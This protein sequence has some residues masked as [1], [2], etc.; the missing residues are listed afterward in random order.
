MSVQVGEA[1]HHWLAPCNE[2]D[3]ALVWCGLQNL[4][5]QAGSALLT[6]HLMWG[7]RG[8]LQQLDDAQQLMGPK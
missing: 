6:M 5:Q 4:L 7:P 8:L 2:L 1:E 3:I